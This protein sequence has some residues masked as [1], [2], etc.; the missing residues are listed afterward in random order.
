M[1]NAGGD[2]LQDGE[3]EVDR[4]PA[5]QDVGIELANAVAE[6]RERGALVNTGDCLLRHVAPAAI[7]DQNLVDA[8]SIE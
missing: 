7:D 3:V 5:R 4:V 8:R 6:R 2:S 1:A